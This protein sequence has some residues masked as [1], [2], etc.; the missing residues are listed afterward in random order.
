[1]SREK[2]TTTM[3]A[4]R[5]IL[6]V[7]V[8][9]SFATACTALVAARLSE[10]NDYAVDGSTLT[11]SSSGSVD[12][13]CDLLAVPRYSSRGAPD[14][15]ACSTCIGTK[16]S[17]AVDYACQR[18]TDKQAKDWFSTM[19][20]CA[21]S[22]YD[23]FSPP[24]SGASFYGCGSYRDE[25]EPISSNGDDSERKRESEIC[26]HD[27]CMQGTLPPCVLCEISMQKTGVE[28]SQLLS[29]DP[30]GSC[31]YTQCLSKIVG[32]CSEQSTRDIVRHCA[33]TADSWNKT[34]CNELGKTTPDAGKYQTYDDAGDQCL[35]DIADC[36]KQH[37]VSA[38]K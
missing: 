15:N 17:A 35:F 38:C 18:G 11:A 8:L 1:M 4:R 10:T 22:P 28:E 19:Q 34:V 9:A 32:C 27:N 31:L 13:K 29:D 6:G 20:G 12:D 23:G 14:A 16:C 25:K 5:V 24:G 33:F 37:C 3:I 26:I 21:Q 7:S 36:F 2:P 30:C